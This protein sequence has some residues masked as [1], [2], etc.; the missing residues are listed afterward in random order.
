LVQTDGNQTVWKIAASDCTFEMGEKR[1]W[2][3]IEKPKSV[4]ARDACLELPWGVKHFIRPNPWF[5]E[6]KDQQRLIAG[7]DKLA[8]AAQH[9]FELELKYTHDEISLWMDGR[10]VGTLALPAELSRIALSFAKGGAIQEAKWTPAENTDRFLPIALHGYR[11][12]GVMKNGVLAL[13]PGFQEIAGIPVKVVRPEESVD[14]GVSRSL[15][16][17]DLCIG[18]PYY[19]RSAFDGAPETIIF[20]VPKRQYSYAYVLCAAEEDAEKVAAFTVRIGR[21]CP[22]G[23]GD[24][25]ADTSITLPRPGEKPADWIQ[26]VGAITYQAAG[27]SVQRPLWLVRVPLKVGTIQDLLADD[28]RGMG[29]FPDY[30]DVELTRHL[31]SEGT[32]AKPTGPASAVHVFGLTLEQSPVT[33]I[34]RCEQVANI[35]YRAEQPS[36]QLHL[37]NQTGKPGRYVVRWTYR[38]IDGREYQGNTP[39]NLAGSQEE[40]VVKLP[41]D[42]GEPGWYEASIRLCDEQQRLLVDHRTSFAILPLDTRRAGYESP[43][44]TW[45]YE[46]CHFGTDRVDIVGPMFLRAG[47]RHTPISTR[48]RPDDPSEKD[49]APYKVTAADTPY[50]YRLYDEPFREWLAESKK[51]AISQQEKYPHNDSALIFHEDNGVPGLQ[52][53]FPPELY[54]GKPKSFTPEQEKL[55]R[56]A[57]WDRAIA[58]SKFYR[59]NYPNVKLVF[60][61]T[62]NSLDIC[63]E[64]FRRKYP[65]QYIDY[66]GVEVLGDAIAPEKLNDMGFQGAWLLK[67]T[68]RKLGYDDIPITACHEWLL[69]RPSSQIGLKAQADWFIRDCLHAL[70]YGF[71]RVNPSMIYDCGD[72]YFHSSWGNGGALCSRYPQLNPRPSYVAI[73]ALTRVLDGAKFIK[74]LNTDSGSTYALEFQTRQGLVYA[75]WVVR[76]ARPATLH[77]SGKCRFT[78][79]DIVGRQREVSADNGATTVPVETSAI[80]ICTKTPVLKV[81]LG[82]SRFPEDKA[83]TSVLAVNRMDRAAQWAIVAASDARL[84]SPNPRSRPKCWPYRTRGVVTLAEVADPQRGRC[85]SVTLIPEKVVPDIFGEYV[86]LRLKEPMAVPGEPQTLGLWVKGNSGWGQMMWEVTDAEGTTWLSCGRDNWGCD[87]LDWPGKAAINFDGWNFLKLDLPAV[88]RK[89]EPVT[90]WMQPHWLSGSLRV[91]Y[92][93]KVTGV[94]VELRR[95]MVYLDKMQPVR[96]PEIRLQGLSAY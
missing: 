49:L 86:F 50:R 36:F 73:A 62:G 64:F 58:I 51:T 22:G 23:R 42:P 85:L 44:G 6:L 16:P 71:H 18:D 47:L 91:Q 37:K 7:W 38:D 67:E 9:V 8:S 94:V 81:T 52:F 27:Q 32:G 39:V 79:V 89:S 75:L 65:K 13:K 66:L 35:F 31:L 48:W 29:Q 92:P 26:Q 54:G 3:D 5:Y 11:R 14:V 34:C 78:L 45:W 76:G 33:M 15:V 61:N 53:S 28:R 93:I 17:N 12:P 43:F 95:K 88:K 4:T 87:M 40:Q 90:V 24:A 77:F 25:I 56:E 70:A 1:M 80:Y 74:A 41:A 82:E 68:A 72:D 21:S 59:A 10:F 83:P 46:K 30:F 19:S 96:N 84:E 63:S 55:F 20:S 60:G 69:S 2:G 57:L